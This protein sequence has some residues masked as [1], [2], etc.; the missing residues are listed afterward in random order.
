MPKEVLDLDDPYDDRYESLARLDLAVGPDV[1]ADVDKV[2][3]MIAVV[4]IVDVDIL[5]EVV[6]D[7]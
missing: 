6:V 2:V 5:I 1:D 4:A 7:N 3:S